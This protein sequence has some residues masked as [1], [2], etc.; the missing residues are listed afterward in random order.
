MGTSNSGRY[1]QQRLA[2]VIGTSQQSINKY[3]N[4]KGEPD[5][6]TLI[7]LADYFNTSIDYLVGR[8]PICGAMEEVRSYD[9]ND[10]ESALVDSYRALLQKQKESIRLVVENYLGPSI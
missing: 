4:H 1:Q 6:D 10:D 3:E 2:D 5:I 8:V 9:L 7:R